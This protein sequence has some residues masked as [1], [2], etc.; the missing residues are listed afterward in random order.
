MKEIDL[1]PSLFDGSAY[2]VEGSSK[3]F[4]R[5]RL[6]TVRAS[7]PPLP[8]LGYPSEKVEV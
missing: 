4:A 6:L 2:S 8:L 7:A 5:L 1:K 3:L